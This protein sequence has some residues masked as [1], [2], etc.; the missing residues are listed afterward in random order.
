M[1]TN[2]TLYRVGALFDA[3]LPAIEQALAKT[4][5][6]ECGATQERSAGW[7]PPRG[8]DHGALVESVA[9]IHAA[10]RLAAPRRDQAR[11][12]GVVRREHGNRIRTRQRNPLAP[13]PA[14]T[15]SRPWRTRR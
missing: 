8:E 13:G 6:A 10:L 1:F 11:V 2:L 4:P 15:A 14:T 12:L 7:V 3:D 9:R 5:F